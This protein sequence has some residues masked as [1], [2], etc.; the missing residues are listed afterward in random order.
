[1]EFI[2]DDVEQLEDIANI[3][4]PA[5]DLPLS[6]DHAMCIVPVKA[7]KER[8]TDQDEEFSS[9][10]WKTNEYKRVLEERVKALQEYLYLKSE[11]EGSIDRKRV[12][13]DIWNLNKAGV[14]NDEIRYLPTDEESM[15]SILLFPSSENWY[16]IAPMLSQVHWD[17]EPFSFPREKYINEVQM[18]QMPQWLKQG[19]NEERVKLEL[20]GADME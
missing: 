2:M 11:G 20:K 1:M 18:D 10:L 9:I 8:I 17:G 15:S 13:E 16:V 6:S 14:L 4:D 12:V 3:E 7:I 5:D 19:L